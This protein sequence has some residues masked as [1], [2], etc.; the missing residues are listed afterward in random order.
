MA[1]NSV[2]SSGPA[3]GNRPAAAKPPE[4]P[5]PEERPVESPPGGD[6]IG[7]V[8][9]LRLFTKYEDFIDYFE[10]IVERFPVYERTVLCA[11]IKNIMYGIYEK[12]IRTNSSKNKLSGWYDIDLDLKILRR[13]ITRTR[14]K[15]SKYLSKRSHETASKHLSEIGKLLG[16]LIKKG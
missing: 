8:E 16:G 14:K 9:K 12:I 13:Y 7:G 1:G 3:T 5:R 10:P 11:R 6:S 15:G 4:N 2:F